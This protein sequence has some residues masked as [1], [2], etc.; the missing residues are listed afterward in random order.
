MKFGMV[1]KALKFV[2]FWLSA[3]AFSV[4]LISAIFKPETLPHVPLCSFK[5]MT[6]RPCPGCG[7]TRSFCAISHGRLGEA[8]YFNPF[9]FV[10][11]A[12][13]V[14]L[15]VWPLLAHFFPRLKS[16]VNQTRLFVWLLPLVLVCMLIY[17]VIRMVNGP[18]V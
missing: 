14:C 6:G 9:G 11:Y 12:A 3:G 17:G 15:A 16:W 7:L 1:W 18:Y 10:F 4:L 8:F 5:Q 13:T 2:S